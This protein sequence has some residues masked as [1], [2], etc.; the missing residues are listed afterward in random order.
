VLALDITNFSP[1][2]DGQLGPDA[3][4]FFNEQGYLAF[5]G[6]IPPDKA[7]KLK[8]ETDAFEKKRGENRGG[9]LATSWEGLAGLATWDPL[10]GVLDQVMGPKFSM[11]HY[12]VAIHEAGN[13]GV[14]WHQDYEQHPQTNRSHTMVHAFFY[15]DGLNGTIGDLMFVP[16][17]HKS[18]ASRG[19][20]SMFGYE[21]L[22]GTKIVDDVPPGT[23]ILVHSA[24]WHARRPQ[25]GGEG[26]P[27]YFLDISYCQEGVKWP[28]NKTWIN[29]TQE[30]LDAGWF[31]S[32]RKEVLERSMFYDVAEV[33]ERCSNLKGS[34]ALEVSA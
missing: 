16:G 8:A 14:R 2:K 34:L 6:F 18:V 20:M 15:L 32:G 30:A 9:F 31:S 25:P 28:L 10:M 17:S 23:M 26:R 5:P 7:E 12:H 19:A 13:G 29:G 27:R 4:E 11:H 22:P 21:L 3:L 24:L 33:H 1:D